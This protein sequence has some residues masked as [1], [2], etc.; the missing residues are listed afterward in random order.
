[1]RVAG[2]GVQGGRVRVCRP[3]G[4]G[5]QGW[6]LRGRGLGAQR[7]PVSKLRFAGVAGHGW[8]SARL[9][10]I[11]VAMLGFAGLGV[12]G[13][14]ARSAA[15]PSP[16]QGLGSRAG[17]AGPAVTA[18]PHP[19]PAT[20][21]P[22]ETTAAE[23]VAA[24]F[25]RTPLQPE[26]TATNP[27]RPATVASHLPLVVLRAHTALSRRMSH[28]PPLLATSHRA[29]H[30][31]VCRPGG[32]RGG[33]GGFGGVQQVRLGQEPVGH[34]RPGGLLYSEDARRM[35]QPASLGGTA[36]SFVRSLGTGRSRAG[37]S[38]V[39]EAGSSTPPFVEV[40]AMQ[41]LGDAPVPNL[42][43]PP[44]PREG[45]KRKPWHTQTPRGPRNQT[46]KAQ[47]KEINRP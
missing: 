18:R 32:D 3:G 23:V 37:N 45:Q 26:P 27:P 9:G 33:G 40:Q 39:R 14:R 16:R 30:S 47:T 42:L 17:V 6:L 19:H 46:T 5:G 43:G 31:A 7:F 44:W 28:A 38:G 29:S 10:S 36:A 22:P 8:E 25:G 21:D 11:R 4:W 13:S 24:V 12:A 41:R 34:S 35:P 20:M 15:P 2:W 1:M